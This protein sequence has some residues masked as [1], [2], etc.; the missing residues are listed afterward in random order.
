MAHE[1][2]E[3]DVRVLCAVCGEVAARVRLLRPGHLPPPAGAGWSREDGSAHES[4][5]TPTGWRFVYEGIEGGNGAGDEISEDQARKLSN[6]FAEPVAFEK[7]RKAGLYDDAGFC[8]D[9][10][11]PYCLEHWRTSPTGYGRCPRGHG[12]SLDPHWSP[13]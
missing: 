11:A 10:R 4:S 3:R 5:G 7:V 1:P 2:E 6:A 13:E 12:K 9:C 8:A